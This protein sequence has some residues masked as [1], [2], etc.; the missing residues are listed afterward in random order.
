MNLVVLF[1]RLGPYHVARLDAV[2]REASLTALELSGQATEY[3]WDPVETPS[4]FERVTVFPDRSHRDVPL[5]DLRDAISMALAEANPDAVVLPGW[6]DPGTLAAL[7]WCRHHDVP[8]VVMSASS[9]LDAPRSWWREAVKRRVVMSYD[10][11][12]VGGE[13]H[14]A[15]LHS[16][17]MPPARTFTGYNVVDNAHFSDGAA[18]ARRRADQIR[19]ELRLPDRYFLAIGRFIPKKNYPFLLNAFAAYRGRVSSPIDLVILG[20]G[21]LDQDLRACRSRLGLED[22]VHLPG[23]KQYEDLPLYYGL[24]DAFVHTSLREQWGLVVNEAMAA[25]LPVIVSERC[26]CV[27]DLIRPGVNGFSFDP[28]DADALASHL[29]TVSEDA[30]LRDTMGTVGKEIVSEWTPASFA[31]Q[32]IRAAQ[33]AQT[34]RT[35]AGGSSSFRSLVTEAL[36]QR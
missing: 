9:A 16:L 25:G 28:E 1:F 33:A 21:P 24:A 2:G 6:D 20:D 14:A 31:R 7:Q 3:A 12:L 4:T 19:T 26:G 36:L 29:Q 32:L 18:D 8:R 35:Q 11:G 30:D 27:P 13:R 34:H 5:Q 10:A 17:G 23:F 22:C 15:Y